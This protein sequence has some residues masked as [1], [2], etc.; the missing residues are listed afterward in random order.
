[1]PTDTDR[2]RSNIG[3]LLQKELSLTTQLKSRLD[4]EYLAIEGRDTLKFEQVVA[5]KA[6]LLELLSGLEQ[7]RV[8]I[9]E[10]AGF[11]AG[12]TGFT[13]CLCRYDP[14]R[15]LVPLWQALQSH[16]GICR[17]L[18]RRN[19]QL[20]ELCSRHVREAL[21]LLRGEDPRQDTY[22]ADGETDSGHSSRS[23]A[24]V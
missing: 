7:E 17:Q 18:N 10:A 16:A 13:D 8:A 15:Q 22:Q 11:D 12:Q 6:R 9:Q 5:E 1:M 3:T 2:C 19:Q 20:V 4:D 21:Y 24:R 14:Q 23:I